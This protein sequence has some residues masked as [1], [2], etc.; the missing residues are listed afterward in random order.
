MVLCLRNTLRL[1]VS[2][3]VAKQVTGII[4]EFL[5]V[6]PVVKVVFCINYAGNGGAIVVAFSYESLLKCLLIVSIVLVYLCVLLLSFVVK[7]FFKCVGMFVFL[8]FKP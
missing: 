5:C 2:Q 1:R 7:Y 8:C 6:A 3:N 4:N